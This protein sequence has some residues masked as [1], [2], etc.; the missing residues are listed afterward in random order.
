M[1][2]RRRHLLRININPYYCKQF[3]D[4]YAESWR[5]VNLAGNQ[6]SFCS[7]LVMGDLLDTVSF[8]SVGKGMKASPTMKKKFSDPHTPMKIER[9][10]V[11]DG[12]PL[13]LQ[14]FRCGLLSPIQRAYSSSILFMWR[15][16]P[17]AMSYRNRFNLK[18]ER[19]HADSS[20]G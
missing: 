1:I 7:A 5:R 19:H 14:A 6:L 13:G 18:M 16:S 3:G 11:V 4:I 12:N 10:I 15:S 20:S 2:K 17:K 8:P 9:E